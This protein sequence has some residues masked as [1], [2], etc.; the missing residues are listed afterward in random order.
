MALGAGFGIGSSQCTV[1]TPGPHRQPRRVCVK[2]GRSRGWFL[3]K[4]PVVM[5]RLFGSE[6]DSCTAASASKSAACGDR[7]LSPAIRVYDTINNAGVIEPIGV[8]AGG[9]PG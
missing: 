2:H 8:L 4:A 5:D 7:S 3:G 9:D 1:I 6:L